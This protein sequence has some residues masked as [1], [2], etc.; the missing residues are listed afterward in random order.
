MTACGKIGV[1]SSSVLSQKLYSSGSCHHR[2]LI[3]SHAEVDKTLTR[4]RAHSCAQ[5]RRHPVRKCSSAHSC[6][7]WRRQP[8]RKLPSHLD[9]LHCRPSSSFRKVCDQGVMERSD[10]TLFNVRVKFRQRRIV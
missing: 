2:L 8:V 6:A 5:C 7:Q 4:W 10:K 3:I 1:R 9:R